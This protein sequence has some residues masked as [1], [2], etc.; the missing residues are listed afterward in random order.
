MTMEP[1]ETPMTST[2]AVEQPPVSQTAATGAELGKRAA[3]KVAM[4]CADEVAGDERGAASRSAHGGSAATD[5]REPSSVDGMPDRNHKDP[6]DRH[7]LSALMG[8]STPADIGHLTAQLRVT[9]G[10]VLIYRHEGKVLHDWRQYLA[11]QELGLSVV[12][13]DV[14]TDD[15]QGFLI[16]AL[17]HGRGWTG[18]Q[19]AATVV[20]IRLWRGPGRPRK[21]ANS[22][23]FSA[24]P[25]R[26]MT[27]AEMAAEADVCDRY[28]YMAKR[29]RRRGGEAMLRRVVDGEISLGSVE[30]GYRTR[31]KN[32]DVGDPEQTMEHKAL[33]ERESGCQ[34]VG[35]AN[36]LDR[37][38]VAAV[39]ADP[40]LT[41]LVLH[42]MGKINWLRRENRRLKN[43]NQSL[44]ATVERRRGSRRSTAAAEKSEQRPG[45]TTGNCS[46]GADHENG[47]HSGANG[48][49]GQLR[50][51]E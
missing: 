42:L 8:E 16:R 35:S 39:A 34:D 37:N 30:Q 4:N 6:L 46:G 50:L 45:C 18:Y 12:F 5:G 9:G 20:L 51:I 17:F 44:T 22:A 24:A 29:V 7:N 26:P 49:N 33:K 21:D 40:N 41:G 27:V 48:V 11:A 14:D 2:G 13:R 32:G 10:P 15:P 38:Q 19:R 1:S 23:G 47:A 25:S 3:G 36:V 43:N 28:I 31:R